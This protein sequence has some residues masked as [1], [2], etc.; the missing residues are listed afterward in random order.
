M[1]A[2]WLED[3]KLAYR[4]DIPEPVPG[5]GEALVRVRLAG[6][7]GTD[8]ELLRGYYPFTG[9]PGHEFVGEVVGFGGE[10]PH[11]AGVSA[12]V[13]NPAGLGLGAR[14]VGEI[15][16]SCG[17]CAPCRRGD[18]T[19]CDR[20]RVLGIR[21]CH[22]SFAGLLTLPLGN[23]HPVPQ[24]VPD[25]AAVFTEPLAAA[26]EILENVHLHPTDRVLVVG[27]G[28]LGQLAAQVLALTGCQLQVV[29][30][31]AV[32]QDR[33]AKRGIDCLRPG[34]VL[35]RRADVVVDA[36]GSAEGFG[37]ARRAVRPRGIIVMKSTYHG[38]MSVNFSSMV[39]DE[40]TLV[41][42][43]CGPFAPAL[44]LLETG[45]VN[46]AELIEGI[47]PL[48]QGLAAFDRASQPGA[49]KIL[50]KP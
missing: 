25:E 2:L 1:N 49:M 17:E 37:L 44:R 45:R 3:Q 15:N 42:S 35:E 31:H 27:A 5:P 4:Q 48:E 24:A 50:F 19:H 33:L 11:P 38:E 46:P 14:V 28:R 16:V 41:G 29:V 6:V 39:V 23:L 9:I 12:G 47:Y 10:T 26:L 20:R 43:R 34:Q 18:R 22:G 8:L 7:C 32:Q 30:R 36:S 40:I 21:D 13:A